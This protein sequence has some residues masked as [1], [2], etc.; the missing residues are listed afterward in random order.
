MTIQAYG[1]G[2]AEPARLPNRMTIEDEFLSLMDQRRRI[3]ARLTVLAERLGDEPG[4][5]G[6]QIVPRA[7]LPKSRLTLAGSR[8]G[9]A[10]YKGGRING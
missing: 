4:A 5:K 10:L 6:A 8:P 7:S 9:L 3:D 1:Q 2:A